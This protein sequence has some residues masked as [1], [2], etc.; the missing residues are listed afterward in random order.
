MVSK[1]NVISISHLRTLSPIGVNVRSMYHL[2]SLFLRQICYYYVLI[3]SS[4]SLLPSSS[5]FSSFFSGLLRCMSGRPKYQKCTISLRRHFSKKHYG[6]GI[7][8][9]LLFLKIFEQPLPRLKS[10]NE[11]N[12]I[13]SLI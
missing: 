8:K 10:V 4:M 12:I 6:E 2:K 5:S 1:F 11:S 13:T 7:G 3:P 9:I